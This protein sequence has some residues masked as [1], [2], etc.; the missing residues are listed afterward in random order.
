[1]YPGV[2][3]AL[4]FSAGGNKPLPFKLKH[5]KP[6]IESASELKTQVCALYAAVPKSVLTQIMSGMHIYSLIYVH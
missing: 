5:D 6:N 2:F 3:I 4:N 1:M